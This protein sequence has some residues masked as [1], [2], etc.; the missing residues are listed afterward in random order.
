MLKSRWAYPNKQK[1]TTQR[2]HPWS[3]KTTVNK[4]KT[5][6]SSFTQ[7]NLNMNFPKQNCYQSI[8]IELEKNYSTQHEEKYYSIELEHN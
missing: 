4:E 6:K 2:R 1:N 5:N 7:I 3:T 8:S